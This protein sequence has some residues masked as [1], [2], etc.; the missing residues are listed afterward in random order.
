MFLHLLC[1]FRVFAHFLAQ[2]LKK[3]KL[4]LSKN[5]TFYK[6]WCLQIFGILFIQ[7]LAVIWEMFIHIYIFFGANKKKTFPADLCFTGLQV[8][9]AM[10]CKLSIALHWY[11][12]QNRPQKMQKNKYIKVPKSEKKRMSKSSILVPL[13]A[14][15]QRVSVSCMQD[16]LDGS[17]EI[18]QLYFSNNI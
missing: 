14:Q 16:L 2:K 9:L 12:M 11:Q 5:I 4:L 17:P 18:D 1:D 3:V 15:V 7:L 10:V 13:S 6:V 8:V